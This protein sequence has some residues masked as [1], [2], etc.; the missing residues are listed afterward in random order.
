MDLS[1]LRVVV[2]YFGFFYVLVPTGTAIW[3]VPLNFV[4]TDIIDWR[5]SSYL[6]QLFCYYIYI[7]SF[8]VY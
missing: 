5:L 1:Y 7:R 6:S 3:N 4:L 2:S 8:L